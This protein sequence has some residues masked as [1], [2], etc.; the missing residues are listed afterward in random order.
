MNPDL[1]LRR[2]RPDHPQVRALLGQLDAYLAAL[3][4][5]EANHILDL[6]ALM[7]PEVVFVT[8]WKGER[9]I[10]TA[11]LRA[12]PAEPESGGVPYAEI[13]RMYVHPEARGQGAGARLLARLE[14]EAAARGLPLA[15]LETGRDQVEA[16]RMYA[17]CGYARRGP[18]A[19]YPD[20][21]LS[22]FMGKR[23]LAHAEATA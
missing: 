14:V 9:C 4:P 10:G 6:E 20:N 19:G 21:G 18:F 17:R 13:K 15:L 23:L 11:A 7:A 3:Y 22:L 16:V 5:P 1:S 2:E 12:M 8:A